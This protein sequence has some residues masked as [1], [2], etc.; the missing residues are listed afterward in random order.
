[1]MRGLYS[2]YD[3]KGESYDPPFVAVSDVLAQRFIAGY[4]QAGESV[5]AK[6]PA[7]FRLYR[8]GGFDDA[9]G[10]VVPQVPPVMVCEVSTL[11]GM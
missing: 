3:M 11:K 4:V 2:V 5:L 9:A 7:D 1:M 8:I 6:F 10:Q